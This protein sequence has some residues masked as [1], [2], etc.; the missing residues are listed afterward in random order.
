MVT[1]GSSFL[2]SG[3]KTCSWPTF[4]AL[5]VRTS[6]TT[7]LPAW[8]PWL[9][10]T[11]IVPPQAASASAAPPPPTPIK[12]RRRVEVPVIADAPLLVRV[13][14]RPR[15]LALEPLAGSARK[16]QCFVLGPLRPWP[17]PLFFQASVRARRLGRVLFDASPSRPK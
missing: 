4:S 17:T 7:L 8:P 13:V 16:R 6:Q 2:S 5:V 14:C 1:L 9:P 11:P 15:G 12:T 3:S 10:G